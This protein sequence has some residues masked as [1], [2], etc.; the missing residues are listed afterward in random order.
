MTEIGKSLP[1]LTDPTATTGAAEMLAFKALSFPRRGPCRA[2]AGGSTAIRGLEY[3]GCATG[4]S[5]GM[6]RRPTWRCEAIRLC[7]CNAS[8]LRNVCDFEAQRVEPSCP[9]QVHRWRNAELITK[10]HRFH[11]FDIAIA[12]SGP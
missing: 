12:V 9:R 7:R 11:D 3:E 2:A 6:T 5:G 4:T 10:R 8:A 1:N